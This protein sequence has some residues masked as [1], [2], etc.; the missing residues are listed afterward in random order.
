M[1]ARG[2]EQCAEVV[3]TAAGV[4]VRAVEVGGGGRERT[5]QGCVPRWLDAACARH[6]DA[7]VE[8]AARLPLRRAAG[9]QLA[10]LLT[11]VRA[12]PARCR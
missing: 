7:A 2:G 11:A 12:P 10:R 1:W 3:R 8:L 6:R 9:R 5:R 4:V